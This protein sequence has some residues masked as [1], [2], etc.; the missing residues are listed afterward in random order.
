MRFLY[1]LGPRGLGAIL[2]IVLIVYALTTYGPWSKSS[3]PT[4]PRADF[5]VRRVSVGLDSSVRA[6]VQAALDETASEIDPASDRGRYRMLERVRDILREHLAGVRY[7]GWVSKKVTEAGAEELFTATTVALH[8]RFDQLTNSNVVRFAPP[9]V[10]ARAEEGGGFVVVSIVT[11]TDT[12][13]ADLPM[14]P[15]REAVDGAL[16]TCVPRFPQQLIALEIVWSPSVD[17]DRLSSA[18]LEMLYPELV[19]VDG[20]APGRVQCKYCRCVSAQELG[21]CPACGSKER[22]AP[23]PNIA[24]M[25]PSTSALAASVSSAQT[26]PCPQ[27]RQ[28]TRFYETQ[29]EHCGARLHA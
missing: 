23:P 29:C 28:P 15:T 16:I 7:A 22:V 27:C 17:Q 18:E 26:I 3:A 6:L 1:A 12:H 4:A 9:E 20:A 24:S 10:R 14:W 25:P 13:L 11:A 2:V 21:E 8:Q 5:E 19:L